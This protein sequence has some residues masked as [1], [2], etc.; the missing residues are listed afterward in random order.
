MKILDYY[1]FEEE[2]FRKRIY[3]KLKIISS[4]VLFT[5]IE[6]HGYNFSP[7]VKDYI[8]SA[9]GEDN[10]I[11]NMRFPSTLAKLQFISFKMPSL[12]SF[13]N[14]IYIQYGA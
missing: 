10:K 14:Q 11:A 3:H 8:Y 9:V 7:Q 4:G 5:I 2:E 1:E 13:V 6:E 12:N